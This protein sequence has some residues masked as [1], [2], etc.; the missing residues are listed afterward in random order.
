MKKEHSPFARG[1]HKV[2]SFLAGSGNHF[3][4]EPQLDDPRF[5]LPWR[6]QLWMENDR[7]IDRKTEIP[8]GFYSTTYTTDRMLEFLKGRNEEEKQQPFLA[9]LAY[10]APH[11]PLQAPRHVSDKYA[12]M[13]DDGPTKLSERRVK[14]LIELGLV[15]ANVVPAKPVGAYWQGMGGAFRSRA[16]RVGSQDGGLRCHGGVD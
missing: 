5:K 10:L 6:G 11:W 3:N 15:P 4:Y 8:K 9:Y 16:S 14:R 7:Y 12:G 13:Y 2:F 1:F